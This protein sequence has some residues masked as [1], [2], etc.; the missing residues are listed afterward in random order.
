M[1]AKVLKLLL[2]KLN[3]LRILNVLREKNQVFI[4]ITSYFKKYLPSPCILT[5]LGEE[6]SSVKKYNK[7]NLFETIFTINH[8]KQFSFEVIHSNSVQ[9]PN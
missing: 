3:T 8:F 2:N 4:Q 5:H 9:Y 6:R 7:H 1:L